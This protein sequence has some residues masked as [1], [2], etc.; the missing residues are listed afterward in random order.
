M[1]AR[2]NSTRPSAVVSAKSREKSSARRESSA[3][4]SASRSIER[5]SVSR[6]AGLTCSATGHDLRADERPQPRCVGVGGVLAPRLAELAQ[7][8]A[9]VRAV[10]V[11]QRAHDAAAHVRDRREPAGAGAGDRAHQE[12]LDAVV[13]RVRDGDAAATPVAREPSQQ[14]VERLLGEAVAHATAGVLEV[15]ALGGGV[16]GDVE[17]HDAA[18]RRRVRRRA[19]GRT[20][21]SASASA[22]RSWWLTCSTESGPVAP[23]SPAASRRSSATESAPPLTIASTGASGG[24]MPRRSAVARAMCETGSCVQSSAAHVESDAGKL[25]GTEGADL[26]DSGAYAVAALLG[27]LDDPAR[28]AADEQRAVRPALRGRP[29]RRCASRWRRRCPRPGRRR[30]GGAAR[31]RSRR[32]APRR[33]AVRA[34][35]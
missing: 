23:R 12:R 34:G 31:R 28:A 27:D 4:S 1:N 21:A 6:K 30:I 17:A 3:S 7:V 2:S 26:E 15:E 5:A 14:R 25:R 24:S 10:A 16:L 29:C 22:P 8:G 11:E 13:A 20:R 9:H 18:P 32:P 33:P 35:P 19:R